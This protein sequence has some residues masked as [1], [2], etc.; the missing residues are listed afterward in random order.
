MFVV[1][2]DFLIHHVLDADPYTQDLWVEG[3]GTGQQYTVPAAAVLHIVEAAPLR[4]LHYVQLAVS[5]A[6]EQPYSEVAGLSGD[7][8]TFKRKTSHKSVTHG[9]R[10]QATLQKVL[11]SAV[12]TGYESRKKDMEGFRSTIPWPSSDTFALAGVFALAS[13]N[14]PIERAELWFDNT[15]ENF[16]LQDS[17]EEVDRYVQRIGMDIISGAHLL[18][19]NQKAVSIHNMF[20]AAPWI[21][22]FGQYCEEHGIRGRE[23]RNT[24]STGIDPV[25][26]RSYTKTFEKAWKRRDPA[27]RQY[28]LRRLPEAEPV[29]L[30]PWIFPDPELG[31]MVTSF[32]PGLPHGLGVAKLSFILELL[33]RDAACLDVRMLTYFAGGDEP[34][35]KVWARAFDHK[36]E[37]WDGSPLPG[38]PLETLDMARYNEVES[39]LKDTPFFDSSYPC[40]YARAQWKLWEFLDTVKGGGF[41]YTI[42]EHQ[43]LFNEFARRGMLEPFDESSV[44]F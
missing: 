17:F 42:A 34:L 43:P 11:P 13:I 7:I 41:K 12:V 24:L 23:L 5:E 9:I 37:V 25:W 10:E 6:M 8:L 29:N 38:R 18:Y 16:T 27:Q 2:E 32:W 19:E 40:P 22:L 39:W 20:E 26:F 3:F 4:V 31:Q 33:G 1:T 28:E 14:V 36:A 21:V 35:G 44:P 15:I 30:F